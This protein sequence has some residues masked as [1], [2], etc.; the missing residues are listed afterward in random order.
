MQQ[1][2][3]LLGTTDSQGIPIG[4]ESGYSVTTVADAAALQAELARGNGRYPL[5]LLD[6]MLAPAPDQAAQPLGVKLT[7]QIKSSAPDAT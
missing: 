5:I 1:L 7:R 4:A 2:R 6:D 3:I